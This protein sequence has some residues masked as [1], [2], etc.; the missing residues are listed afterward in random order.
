MLPAGWSDFMAR[1]WVVGGIV[2]SLAWFLAGKQSLSNKKPDAAIGWQC[3]AVII[4]LIVSGWA[5]VEKEWFGLAFAL[6]VLY[7]EVRSVRRISAT[8]NE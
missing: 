1:H 8:R 5:V 7:I 2:A 6:G 4:I 3:V